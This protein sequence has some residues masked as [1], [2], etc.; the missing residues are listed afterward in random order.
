[1]RNILFAL[2]G[3]AITSGWWA[4]GTGIVLRAVMVPVIAATVLLSF[5]MLVFIISSALDEKEK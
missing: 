1:M 4:I 3:A 2:W 5:G